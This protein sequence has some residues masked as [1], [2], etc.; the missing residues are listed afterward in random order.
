M[1]PRSATAR[2]KGNGMEGS[3]ILGTLSG[4]LK[5]QPYSFD[6]RFKSKDGKAGTNPEELIAAAH[7]GCYSMA[8][9]FA[10]SKA[11][12]PP[13]ELNCR[14]EV[15]MRQSDAGFTIDKI[16]LVVVGTVPGIAAEKF[17]ELAEAAKV[18]CP[19]SKALSAVPIALE[20]SLA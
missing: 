10:L 5:D 4:A 12:T 9:S 17:A 11:G 7:A 13:K 20:A 1:D 18:G 3:G 6:T 14:A 19:V 16:R 15:S 2:W 8:L